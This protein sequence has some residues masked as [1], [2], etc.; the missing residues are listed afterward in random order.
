MVKEKHPIDKGF[1]P[2]GIKTL[3]VGTFPPKTEYENNKNLFFYNSTRNHFWN[4]M[5]NIFPGLALKKTKN[6]CANRT[7]EQNKIDKENFAIAKSIGFLDIFT[8]VSRKK[9]SSKDI[10]LIPVESI[11]ENKILFKILD[12]NIELTKICCTYNLAY[13]VFEEN[14]P[15]ELLA[16]IANEKTA[17]QKELIYK[18]GSRK[19]S[20]LLLF[21]ATRS[22]QKNEV[23]DEQYN[24]LIFQ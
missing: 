17:N 1:I 14:L 5:E 8:K 3:I 18:Y 24:S 21:P 4:R 13:E 11:I 23:K 2:K 19:I 20:I 7:P 10:D 12:D 22:R 9:D 16:E 15:K 6:K